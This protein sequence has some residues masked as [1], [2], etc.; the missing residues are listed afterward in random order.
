M[1]SRHPVPTL[2]KET[3]PCDTASATPRRT[4]ASSPTSARARSSARRP[5]G[6]T[7][8]ARRRPASST[9]SASPDRPPA[10]AGLTHLSSAEPWH[11]YSTPKLPA[12]ANREPAWALDAPLV[13]HRADRRT[14]QKPGVDPKGVAMVRIRDQTR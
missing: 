7:R 11:G 3:A 4:P 8:P 2:R 5:P 10:S 6:A 13:N 1:Q 9:S 12:G 14:V